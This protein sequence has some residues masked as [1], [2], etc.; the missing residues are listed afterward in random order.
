MMGDITVYNRM[1]QGSS[2]SIIRR[3]CERYSSHSS[4]EAK[5]SATSS[6]S[7]RTPTLTSTPTC[8]SVHG[9]PRAHAHAHTHV[10]TNQSSHHP[11]PPLQKNRHLTI[12]TASPTH[13]HQPFCPRTSPPPGTIECVLLPQNVLSYYRMCSLMI[14]SPPPVYQ[15]VFPYL[16]CP[17]MCSV[18]TECVLL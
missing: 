10:P 2:S 4:S 12:K 15:N 18:N 1:S 7:T 11:P 16:I 8:T 14:D 9:R 5:R 13:Q 3:A 6:T 17:R